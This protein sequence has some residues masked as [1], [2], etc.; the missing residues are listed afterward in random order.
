LAD[1]WSN[2]I[3]VLLGRYIV[4]H[5]A[6]FKFENLSGFAAESKILYDINEGI[7]GG[8]DDK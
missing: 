4:T 1:C 7:S 8:V 6:T 2:H 3:C 5:G